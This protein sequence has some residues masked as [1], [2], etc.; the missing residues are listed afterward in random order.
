MGIALK[1]G[2][3]LTAQTAHPLAGGFL[4]GRTGTILGLFVSAI[5]VLGLVV[6]AGASSKGV[7]GVGQ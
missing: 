2:A 1:V 3:V 7:V 5:V 6:A 4:F